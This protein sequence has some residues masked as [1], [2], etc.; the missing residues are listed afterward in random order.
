MEVP[1]SSRVRP[2]GRSRGLSCGDLPVRDVRS[3][4]VV[5]RRGT[6]GCGGLRS[7]GVH[8]GGWG[9]R[10]E[11]SAREC[12]RGARDIGRSRRTRIPIEQPARRS[13]V[14]RDLVQSRGG[15]IDCGGGAGRTVCTNSGNDLDRTDIAHGHSAAQL[16][17]HLLDLR[18]ARRAGPEDGESASIRTP[19]NETRDHDAEE[20]N[21]ECDADENLGEGEGST[22]SA[23][24]RMSMEL[25]KSTVKRISQ[26]HHRQPSFPPPESC[27][28]ARGLAQG[29]SG[30]A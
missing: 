28:W 11:L 5:T 16:T 10:G 17:N 14:V 1:G 24:Q 13:E 3:R 9:R 27:P 7:G 18:I 30:A 15:A 25:S 12:D 26:T 4:G 2:R 21:G 29:R 8:S 20:H 6:C 23:T 19:A 22:W